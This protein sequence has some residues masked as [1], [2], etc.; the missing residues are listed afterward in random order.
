MAQRLNCPACCGVLT[1]ERPAEGRCAGKAG[2]MPEVGDQVA[3]RPGGARSSGSQR[4]PAGPRCCR[5]CS[6]HGRPR[7]VRQ[8]ARRP[9][10]ARRSD[11]PPGRDP[12]DWAALAR[13][14]SG[15]LIRPGESG[16]ATAKELFDPRFDS[17][18]PAGIAYCRQPA[19]RIHLPGLRQPVR[20][21]GGRPV[22][23]A[24]L[25]GLVVDQRP[26]RGRD[27]MSGVSVSGGTAI[28]GAGPGSST[29]TAGSRPRAARCPA[30]PARR[31][32]SPA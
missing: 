20:R 17:L 14:L 21:P 10:R 6:G 3:R 15:P 12:A 32:A 22:R 23:R 19:R 7:R 9:G 25:R 8:R 2:P 4:P 26:D 28:V 27:P 29:S 31:S 18:H 16:Y 30:V 24:Q 13:D 5:P 1:L 11:R